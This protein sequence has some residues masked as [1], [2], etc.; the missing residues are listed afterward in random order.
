MKKL[1]DKQKLRTQKLHWTHKDIETNDIILYDSNGQ[2][3][4]IIQLRKRDKPS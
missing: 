2:E 3:I 4:N 1:T